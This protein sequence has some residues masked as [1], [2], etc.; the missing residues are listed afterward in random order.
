MVNEEFVELTFPPES[1]RRVP[2]TETQDK[3]N[4]VLA[5]FMQSVW[6]EFPRVARWTWNFTL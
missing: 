6:Q 4:Q 3:E 2:I 1:P 5:V